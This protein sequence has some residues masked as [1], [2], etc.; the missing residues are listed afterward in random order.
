MKVLVF[1]KATPNREKGLS[2]TDEMQKMF[3]EMGKFN[4]ALVKTGVMQKA[5]E[6]LGR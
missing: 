2:P 5:D 3:A 6:G 1:V 4:E